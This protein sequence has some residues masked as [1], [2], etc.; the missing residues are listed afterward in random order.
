MS[1]WPQNAKIMNISTPTK[2]YHVFLAHLCKGLTSG[3]PVIWLTPHLS[4]S[5]SGPHCLSLRFI[6]PQ[7]EL[8]PGYN[9]LVITINIGAIAGLTSVILVSLMSQPRIFYSMAV[10]GFMPPWAAKVRLF[11][12]K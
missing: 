7:A 9:W 6:C 3:Q 4:L 12:L 2:S 8:V 1:C 5:G 10:D 11:C